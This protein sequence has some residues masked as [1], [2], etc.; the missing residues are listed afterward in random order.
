MDA[1]DERVYIQFDSDVARFFRGR[2][3]FYLDKT[4]P[5]SICGTV[6]TI[7]LVRERT[8]YYHTELCELC[9]YGEKGIMWSRKKWTPK[10]PQ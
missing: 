5:C 10:P 7:K 8:G 6:P 3:T 4:I 1:D 9:A 2:F